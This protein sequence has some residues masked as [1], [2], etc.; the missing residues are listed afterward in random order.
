MMAE[1]RSRELRR[2]LLVLEEL[3]RRDHRDAIPRA[4][5]VTQRAANAAGEVDRA[6]LKGGL[7]A[8]AGNSADAID[9]AYRQTGFAAG[10][11]VLV[12][13]RQSFRKLFLRRA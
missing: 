13:Q 4:D 7:M 6:D 9:R 10:A 11:H 5:L 2:R 12:E 3:V 1:S 8:R